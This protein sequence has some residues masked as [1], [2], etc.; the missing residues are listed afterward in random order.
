MQQQI[1]RVIVGFFT[2][3]DHGSDSVEVPCTGNGP[4]DYEA[5]W[6]AI[7][8]KYPKVTDPL[9]FT[10]VGSNIELRDGSNG[11]VELHEGATV[12]QVFDRADNESEELARVIGSTFFHS[13][14]FNIVLIRMRSLGQ[15]ALELRGK[16]RGDGVIRLPGKINGQRL[17]TEL[18]LIVKEMLGQEAMDIKLNLRHVNQKTKV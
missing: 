18:P 9:A 1:Q 5:L 7:R 13:A 10:R 16:L 17:A 3:K 4:K 2:I 6:K 15:I 12:N 8:D 14:P 11:Y